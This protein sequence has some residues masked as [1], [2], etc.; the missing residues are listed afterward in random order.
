MGDQS[1]P[2]GWE[3]L[4]LHIVIAPVTKSSGQSS[5]VCGQRCAMPE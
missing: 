1:D 2:Q 5:W 3:Q 4:V